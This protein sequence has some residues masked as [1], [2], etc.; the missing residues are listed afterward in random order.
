MV[1]HY[2][3]GTKLIYPV[4]SEK[5][6]AII[7]EEVTKLIE[8]AYRNT[9]IIVHTMKDFVSKGS[10]ILQEEGIIYREK[11]EEML[12]H[13]NDKIEAEMYGVDYVIDL[14]EEDI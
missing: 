4:N 9:E 3:M 1:V 10:I 11:L 13:H 7:D 8:H 5:Y 12:Q 6:K 2:G 14:D